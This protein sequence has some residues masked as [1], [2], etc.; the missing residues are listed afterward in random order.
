MGPIEANNNSNTTTNNNNKMNNSSSHQNNFNNN[1]NVPNVSNLINHSNNNNNNNNSN[2]ITADINN[3]NAFNTAYQNLMSLKSL[4]SNNTNSLS[5]SNNNNR[6]YPLY[7]GYN[8]NTYLNNNNNSENGFVEKF[9]MNNENEHSKAT[10]YLPIPAISSYPNWTTPAT[11]NTTYS[12]PYQISTTSESTP[13]STTSASNTNSAYYQPPTSAAVQHPNN[14]VFYNRYPGQPNNGTSSGIAQQQPSILTSQQVAALSLQSMSEFNTQQPSVLQHHQQP[15]QNYQQTFS[16]PSLQLSPSTSPLL[17]P[18]SSNIPNP[19][20]SFPN[21]YNA[22]DYSDREYKRKTSL[23]I[24]QLPIVSNNNHNNGSNSTFQS[25]QISPRN[26]DSNGLISP[27]TTVNY[28]SLED[29]SVQTT[30]YSLHD[31]FQKKIKTESSESTPSSSTVNSPRGNN[32]INNSFKF[33]DNQQSPTNSNCTSPILKSSFSFLNENSSQ[34]QSSLPIVSLLS[35]STFSNNYNNNSFQN[36]NNND[37]NNNNNNI[38]RTCCCISIPIKSDNSNK[39]AVDCDQ[40]SVPLNLFDEWLEA[41]GY[42]NGVTYIKSGGKVIGAHADRKTLNL[43]QEYSEKPKSN[44]SRK[45]KRELLWTQ[46]YVCARAGLP[47][48]RS[49]DE[50]E[51]K[52]KQQQTVDGNTS[53]VT[54]PR[55]KKASSKKCGCQCR[56]VISV[57]ADDKTYAVVRKIADHSAHMSDEQVVNPKNQQQ[58]LHKRFCLVHQLS[59]SGS[60]IALSPSSPSSLNQYN[61][62]ASNSNSTSSSAIHSPSHSPSHTPLSLSLT[63][64]PSSSS[65]SSSSSFSTSLS[66]AISN[67]ILPSSSSSSSSSTTSSFVTTTDFKL[68]SA[69]NAQSSLISALRD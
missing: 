41:E 18:N 60:S 67:T 9:S 32:N 30:T 69:L 27:S 14:W 24:S 5:T 1:T 62:T 55:R 35:S 58:Q 22:I 23:K 53:P 12:S 65:L 54:T 61:N 11:A 33:F 17:S 28:K 7:Q 4:N 63:N 57:Y 6:V 29:W 44:G 2:T 21:A 48:R 36:N 20:N 49:D 43:K 25:P 51:E 47:S 16:Q 8:Q 45:T 46:K 64:I 42:I 40:F 3:T 38:T 39:P 13:S 10:I 31:G 19:F 15:A 56:I 68:E 34:Q 37:N 66:A 26:I 50:S 52:Q 59:N